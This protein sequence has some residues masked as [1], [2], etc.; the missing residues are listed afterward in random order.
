M[1]DTLSLQMIVFQFL[2]LKK[3]KK[4]KIFVIYFLEFSSMAAA[5]RKVCV[6]TVGTLEEILI[7]FSILSLYTGRGGGGRHPA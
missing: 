1:L 7:H 5:G 2:I 4:R 3:K 6:S